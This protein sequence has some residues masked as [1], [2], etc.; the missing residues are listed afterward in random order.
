MQIGNLR[1]GCSAGSFCLSSPTSAWV[2]LDLGMPGIMGST[3][4][5]GRSV[6]SLILRILLPELGRTGASG[7]YTDPH[8]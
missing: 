1:T 6:L 2:M 7:G 3:G 4:V 5:G 8:R